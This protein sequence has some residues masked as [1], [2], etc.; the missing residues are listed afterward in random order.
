VIDPFAGA[1]TTL[2][3]AKKLNR[4]AVGVELNPDYCGLAER[5]LSQGVIEFG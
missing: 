5:R 1:G 4:K 3:M 2:W